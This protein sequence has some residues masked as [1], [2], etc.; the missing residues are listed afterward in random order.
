MH[1]RTPGGALWA[2]SLLCGKVS[3]LLV[4]FLFQKLHPFLPILS[5]HTSSSRTMCPRQGHCPGLP[6]ESSGSSPAILALSC[7][8]EPSGLQVPICSR[9]LW[10]LIG[11]RTP[12]GALLLCPVDPVVHLGFLVRASVRADRYRRLFPWTLLL[13]MPPLPSSAPSL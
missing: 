9:T 7:S 2:W 13:L 11:G 3:S 4:S 1:M 8:R 5:D 10:A 6:R 12:W